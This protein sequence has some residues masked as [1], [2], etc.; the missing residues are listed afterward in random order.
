[1]SL[2]II[3]D[4]G[5]DDLDPTGGWGDVPKADR[6]LWSRYMVDHLP[7]FPGVTVMCFMAPG[8]MNGNTRAPEIWKQTA[9]D[10]H[11]AGFTPLSYYLL[12]ELLKSKHHGSILDQTTHGHL[13]DTWFTAG[14]RPT[15][16]RLAATAWKPWL[17]HVADGESPRRALEHMLKGEKLAPLGTVVSLSNGE[18]ISRAND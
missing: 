3:S 5:S 12:A 17:E 11:A 6:P 16:F 9:Q 18:V 10:L 8:V 4:S 2:E 15:T 7:W 1:M 13:F 14:D